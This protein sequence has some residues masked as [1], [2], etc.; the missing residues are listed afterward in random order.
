MKYF[1][2]LLLTLAFLAAQA[3][4]LDIHHID[5]GQGDATFIVSKDSTGT[6]AKTVLID[7]GYK[8]DGT[9]IINYIT[10]TLGIS[11]INYV[12][13]SHYDNDHVG[14]L[15]V[16]LANALKPGTSLSV[17]SVFDRGTT[18][19]NNPKKGAGY[20]K[21]AAKFG[22]A[23]KTIATGK[24]ITLFD[25]K[26]GGTKTGKYTIKMLCL[27]VNGIII[28]GSTPYYNA[29]S[30][31]GLTKPD[32]NDLSTGFLISY[33]K[34]KYLTCGDIGGKRNSQP[35][36]CD[37]KYSCK[38]LDIET[39]VIGYTGEVSCYKINHHGSR[40][41]SNDNWISG[42]RSPVAIISSGRTSRYKHPREEVVLAL[43][44]QDSLK[45]FYMTASVNYY[46][47]TLAPKGILN[48]TAG[49]PI[50]LSVG[51]TNNGVSILTKSVFK[52]ANVFY[53]K[54]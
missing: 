4:T 40:C 11:K 43:N 21:E 32:E 51:R 54:N 50:D 5:V 7:G 15:A 8:K 47:R 13:A 34:F 49:A 33:G 39:N 42:A 52:V 36:T 37:G 14:G 38:F 46:A 22:G 28:T 16:V 27:C 24:L 44:A 19:Y 2:S 30:N 17:D 45:K 9:K 25:D 41:S 1:V 26:S 12:I 23:H 6:V 10:T 48:P 20:K 31:A 3:Q 29:V 35:A 53:T 18:L